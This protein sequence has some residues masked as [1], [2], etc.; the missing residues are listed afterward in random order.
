MNGTHH[1]NLSIGIKLN[2]SLLNFVVVVVFSLFFKIHYL[3]LS[4]SVFYSSS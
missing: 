1:G 4:V 3:I 2:V